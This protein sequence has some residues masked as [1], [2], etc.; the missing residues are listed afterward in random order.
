MGR[1]GKPGPGRGDTRRPFDLL[2]SVYDQLTPRQD[3]RLAQEDALPDDVRDIATR[4]A[5]VP[6]PLGRETAAAVLAAAGRFVLPWEMMRAHAITGWVV[7]EYAERFDVHVSDWDWVRSQAG[8]DVARVRDSFPDDGSFRQFLD[9]TDFN[10]GLACVRDA[11]VE[12]K[13]AGV[14]A[15]L[16]DFAG[17]AE[18]EFGRCVRLECV[19]FENWLLKYVPLIEGDWIDFHFLELPEWC[20]LL[21][22]RGCARLPAWDPHPLAWER[23]FPADVDWSAPA[24]ADPALCRQLREEARWHLGG[25]RGRVREVG[26]R[27]HVRL[28]DYLAWP[29]RKVPGDLTSS[30]HVEPGPVVPSWNRWVE[31]RW[32]DRA[33]GPY[34]CGVMVDKMTHPG[35]HFGKS[36]INLIESEEALDSALAARQELLAG[37][38]KLGREL[39]QARGADAEE[40][41]P[42]PLQQRIMKAVYRRQLTTE[43]LLKEVGGDRKQLFGRWGL[44]GLLERGLVKNNYDRKGYYRPD[45]PPLLDADSP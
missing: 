2:A 5:R 6:Y 30:P 8:A 33:R 26:G 18:V 32:R 17:R 12:A 38:F 25:L 4:L 42:S 31:A 29:Q 36:H 15:E 22:E 41:V 11:D 37:L 10:Y 34:L 13:V 44:R 43:A 27:P 45:A 40:F 21:T 39:A 19:P 1:Q 35:E 24:E 28:E 23:F 20:A 7:Q 3:E 14:E 9:G 16:W